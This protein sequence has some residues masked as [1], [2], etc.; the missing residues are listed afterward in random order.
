M[1]INNT[2]NIIYNENTNTNDHDMNIENCKK[3]NT[4][5]TITSTPKIIM[6]RIM[7][8]MAIIMGIKMHITSP[9]SASH[10]THKQ[11]QPTTKKL[12]PTNL[13]ILFAFGPT[14]THYEARWFK[15]AQMILACLSGVPLKQNWNPTFYR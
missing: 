9:K 12:E 3:K 2:N 8:I 6:T 11:H 5:T 15:I 10:P 1:H 4:I 13:P 14:K 7:L